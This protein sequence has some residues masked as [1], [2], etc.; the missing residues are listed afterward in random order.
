MVDLM[1]A[2]TAVQKAGLM[3]VMWAAMM[4]A[5]RAVSKA[6]SKAVRLAEMTVL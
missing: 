5:L 4:V 2:S 1:D 3:V 6:V